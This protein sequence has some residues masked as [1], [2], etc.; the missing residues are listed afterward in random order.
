MFGQQD[1]GGNLFNNSMNTQGNLFNN[2]L[3][4]MTNRGSSADISAGQAAHPGTNPWGPV[5]SNVATGVFNSIPFGRN[6]GRPGGPAIDYG[7]GAGS[8]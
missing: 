8:W 1:F 6:N 7:N 5:M 2:F 4:F 3:N